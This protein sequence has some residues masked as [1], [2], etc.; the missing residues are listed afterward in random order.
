MRIRVRAVTLA[1]LVACCACGGKRGDVEDIKKGQK[2]IL[3]RLAALEKS[4]QDVKKTAA[5][6][7]AAAPARPQIDPAK[8]YNVPLSNSPV[9]GPSDAK[10]TVVEFADYQCPFCGQAEGLMNQVL[11]SYP[12]EVRLV[13]K[14]FPLSTIHPQAM[15][16]S[17]AA[18]AAGRQGK[19]WEM[20]DLIF[21]NQRDLSPEKLTQLAGSLQLDVMQFQKDMESPEV[22]A[23]ISREQ[24]EGKSADVVGTPTIF[25]NGKRLINRSLDGFRQMIDT[26]LGGTAAGRAR[27]RRPQGVEPAAARTDRTFSGTSD[28]PGSDHPRRGARARDRTHAR[29]ARRRARE[30]LQAG[31]ALAVGS[32]AE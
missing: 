32:G 28:R 22:L 16:A 4:V 21:R 1:L 8:V 2:E 5:A 13:Y 6:G 14:Q 12:K 18:L 31:T 10:V 29:A 9:R 20:H 15:A 26:S 23:Q 7:P 30:S 27:Q 17:K 3:D 11:A 24:Q 25:V 19:Y